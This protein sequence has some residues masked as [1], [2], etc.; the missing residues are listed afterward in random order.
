MKLGKLV[1]ASPSVGVVCLCRNFATARKALL[2]R[3]LDAMLAAF[4]TVLIAVS[5]PTMIGE[6]NIQ[7]KTVR[8]SDEPH[9]LR[10]SANYDR[11]TKLAM[12]GLALA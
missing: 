7:H 11:I 5:S 1:V 9:V 4:A 12:L 10:E 8:I 2:A 6:F 3:S